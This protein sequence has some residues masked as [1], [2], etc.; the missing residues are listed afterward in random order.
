MTTNLTITPE[1]TITAG[2]VSY[3]RLSGPV[4]LSRLRDA[5]EQR[6]LHTDLLPKPPGDAVAL[7]RAVY[8]QASK[9]RL[10]RPLAKRGTWAIVDETVTD[11]SATFTTVM[12]VQHATG[13]PMTTSPFS[14]EFHPRF[15]EYA[16][17]WNRVIDAYH[18]H[19]N[20]L[21]PED[22][23]S[24]LIKLA[25]TQNSLALRD[26]GGIYF[27]PRTGVDFW[28]KVSA[29]LESV[30]AHKVLK[31]P[32]M[33]NDEA[34]AAIL[35]S[36]SVEAQ[37]TIMAF[38]RDIL[39]TGDEALGARALETRQK[40]CVSLLAKVES[41]ETLLGVSLVKI[42]DAIG[43]LQANIAAAALSADADEAA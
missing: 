9:H 21:A 19:N 40:E 2:L 17:L 8:E 36:L 39:K 38:E 25:H 31:I 24:W 42:T 6:G 12:T 30:S 32:A 11:G 33:K 43:A 34:V 3:W 16:V 20:E 37:S 26:T 22:I 5:F 1:S 18:R 27:I 29:A 41:Y 4:T 10:V 35:E 23:S 15:G 13:R 14:S 28:R 7:G